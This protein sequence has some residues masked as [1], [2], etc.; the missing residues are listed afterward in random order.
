MLIFGEDIKRLPSR[1]N[2]FYNLTYIKKANS[3]FPFSCVSWKRENTQ[4]STYCT[5]PPPIVVDA[6]ILVYAMF[7]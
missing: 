7:F 3:C 2:Q 6:T 5:L 4:T 1:V